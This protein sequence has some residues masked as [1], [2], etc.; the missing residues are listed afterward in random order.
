[1]ESLGTVRTTA[2]IA[3]TLRKPSGRTNHAIPVA[4]TLGLPEADLPIDPYVLGAWLGDGS[5]AGGGFTGIDPE[6]WEEIERAGFTVTHA[7]LRKSHYIKGLAPLLRQIGVLGKKHIPPAYL[8]GSEKQRAA[9]LAGL[10]DTDGNVSGHAVEFANTNRDLTEGVAHLARSLGHKITV[11]EFR[12]K[13]YG[14]DCGPGWRV[15]FAANRIV[16]RLPRKVKAQ[17]VSAHR[18]TRFHYIVAAEPIPSVPAR[19]IAVDSPSHL[20]LAGRS[21]IPTHNSDALL[22]DG[23]A[24]VNHPKYRCLIL[25][26][27]FPE[28]RELMDRSL[29][30]FTGIGGV[31]NEQAKRWRFPSGSTYEF[32]YCSNYREAQQFQG[33]EYTR[34]AYDEI[35]QLAEERVWTFLMSRNR[36]ASPDLRKEMRASANPGG[37]GHFWVKRRFVDK[38]PPDGEPVL[39]HSERGALHG[40]PSE[41]YKRAY[42]R[43]LLKDNPKLLAADPGYM[44]R[45][46]E[47]PELEYRWLALGDWSAGGGLAFP[48]LGDRQRYIIQQNSIRDTSNLFV[49]GGLDW[50]YNHPWS[51]GLYAQDADQ[52]TYCLDTI[53][54]RHDQPP[55]ITEKIL[56]CWERAGVTRGQVKY[57]V[58]GHDVW[59]DV[60]A[61]SEQIPT[62]AEQFASLNLPMAKASISRVA[63]VQNIRRYLAP[64]PDGVPRF[65]W[66]KTPGNEACYECVAS[67][68]S[69]PDD[70]EDVLKQ[71]ADDAGQGGDDHYDALRYSLAARPL[72][73]GLK[74]PAPFKQQDKARHFD[75]AKRKFVEPSREQGLEQMLG[76]GQR[77]F[78]HAPRFTK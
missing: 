65:R 61:R 17:K 14:K 73:P 40:E 71:D 15:K 49:W 36:S 42:F 3:A 20:F 32:N 75:F 1:V 4:G 5:S 77:T 52:N 13:L 63:G 43:S 23:L 16:F 22:F 24:Q 2:E 37:P 55:A 54:G 39:V 11:R 76:M 51:Y 21:L 53:S 28:L 58:A 26:R 6:I 18:T 50:G 70:V 10:L 69:D 34:I 30:A 41:P 27:T 48:E 9:L 47:L 38:C 74:A 78:H 12:T 31:W 72:V 7:R 59:A 29:A 19:C 62:L 57:T 25:R 8:W 68:I 46:E 45:L 66:L 60:K 64:R 35:G 56:R 33:Q 67:R 44:R